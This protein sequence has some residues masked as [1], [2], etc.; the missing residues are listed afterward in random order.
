MRV[1]VAGDGGYIGAVLVPFFHAAGQE[2][3]GLDLGLYDGCDLGPALPHTARRGHADMRDVTASQLT[4]YDAVVCLAALSNDPLGDLNPAA[5][6]SVN[7]DGTLHLARTAKE[8]GVPRFLFSSSCSLYGAA[9]SSA[10]GED[11]DL[12]PVTAYGETKVLAERELSKLA[13]DN[14]S[15]TYLRNATAYGA[16]TRLRLD[17]V[18]NN[19]TAIALTTRKVH[20]QSD[21]TPWRPLVHIEDISRA[22]LAMLEAPREKVHDEAFNV[23]RAEDNLQVRDIAEMVREAVPG[24]SITLADNAGPDLRDYRVDFSKLSE[25]FPELRMRWRVRGGVTELLDSYVAH[26]LTYADFTSARYV[27]L[28]R[29]RDLLAAGEVDEQLRRP[30]HPVTSLHA[31]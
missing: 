30:P 18:V 15:P 16:S 11:A 1:L 29:I 31:R 24:A 19:L 21:G 20:L 28:R 12:N 10:V 6:Y 8:A 26:G 5:T 4:G 27:R 25:T 9:G 2:V 3:T 7:L 22:F 14:F 23:G 13:D 17:I